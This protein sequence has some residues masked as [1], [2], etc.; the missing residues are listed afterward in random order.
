M[1]IETSD[2]IILQH[3]PNFHGDGHFTVNAQFAEAEE[4]YREDLKEF[5]NNGWAL[6]GLYKSLM[7]QGKTKEAKK[8]QYQYN[9]A[10]Q[11]ADQALES[12]VF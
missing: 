6:M 3:D 9:V 10:W 2:G 11:W 4:V 7:A 12:S 8:V 5:R 1:I